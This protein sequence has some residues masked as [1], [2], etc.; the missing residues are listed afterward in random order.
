MASFYS[1]VF[2]MAVFNDIAFDRSIAPQ[3][4]H[5]LWQGQRSLSRFIAYVAELE[6]ELLAIRAFRRCGIPDLAVCHGVPVRTFR[7][8]SI[9]RLLGYA[10][11]AEAFTDGVFEKY[12]AGLILLGEE[13]APRAWNFGFSE[14]GHF[15]EL[16]AEDEEFERRRASFYDNAEYLN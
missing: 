1:E 13:T 7:L 15:E 4:M 9:A 14:G 2:N 11:M 6:G 16:R 10:C 5:E 8:I 12:I 3:G